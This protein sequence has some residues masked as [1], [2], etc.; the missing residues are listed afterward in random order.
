MCTPNKA[1]RPYLAEMLYL[2][3]EDLTQDT[4]KPVKVEG[5]LICLR[6]TVLSLEDRDE[7][8]S[9]IASLASLASEAASLQKDLKPL[10]GKGVD[11]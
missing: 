1:S 5:L 10:P 11:A 9:V 7:L 4:A 2:D 3:I 8:T 6:R